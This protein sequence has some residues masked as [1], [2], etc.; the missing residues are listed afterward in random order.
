MSKSD[1]WEDYAE[2][3]TPRKTKIW[4]AVILVVL[5]VAP[6]IGWGVH[7]ATSGVQGQGDQIVHN[8]EE[9]NRTG[10]QE[11]FETLYADV[12]GYKVQITN[13]VQAVK[14]NTDPSDAA[15]L[16]SIVTGVKNQCVSVV[17]QYNAETHKVTSKDWKDVRLPYEIDPSDYC[18]GSSK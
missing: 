11:M 10:K 14:D 17:Q 9:V 3:W 15:R 7:V 1:N 16:N 2:T 6:A 4:V 18:S 12:Q 13:S 8:N 5:F